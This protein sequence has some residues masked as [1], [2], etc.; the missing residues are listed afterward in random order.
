MQNG[1]RCF[2]RKPGKVDNHGC[3]GSAGSQFM[4]GTAMHI[5][6]M[7]GDDIGPEITEVTM[8]ML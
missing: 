6:V 5:V 1:R 7:P 2:P 8:T 3:G 4:K